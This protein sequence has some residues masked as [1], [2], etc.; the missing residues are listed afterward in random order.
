LL[1]IQE[2]LKRFFGDRAARNLREELAE[3][4]LRRY[5]DCSS[6]DW[7]WFEDRLTYCNAVLPHALFESGHALGR[8]EMVEA[9]GQALEWLAR[10]QTAHRGHF[11]PIGSNGFYI[12]G[13][14][15]ARFDQQP[16]EAQATVSACLAAYAVTNVA[17][18]LEYAQTAFDWFLG[19]NDLGQSL[20]DAETGG[21]R[22]GLHPDRCNENQGAESTLAFLHALLEMRPAESLVDPSNSVPNLAPAAVPR[23]A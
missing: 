14:E 18:W 23:L 9:A 16:I 21:C 5:Q 8:K 6:A 4:L 22:D 19:R 7:K 2:Y 17:G 11:V 12:R 15:R 10:L 3:R 20:F 13:A 1:G